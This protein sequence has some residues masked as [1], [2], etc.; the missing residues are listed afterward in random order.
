MCAT[1]TNF[2]PGREGERGAALVV[3]LLL[4]AFFAGVIADFVYNIRVNSYITANQVEQVRAKFVAEAGVNAARGI[5]LHST[6]FSQGGRSNFQNDYFNLFQCKCYTNS[7]LTGMTSSTE[8]NKQAQTKQLNLGDQVENKATDCGEWSLVIDYTMDED[9]LHL[10]IHDEQARI[11][12]NALVKKSLNPDEQGAALN[13]AFKPVVSELFKIRLSE[14]GMTVDDRELGAL[15]NL[16]VDW[17]DW[18]QVNGT[19]D[20]DLNETYQDG[21]IIY[22]NKNGPMDTVSELKMIPGITDEIYYA[23][24]DFLTV[25]PVNP[26]RGDYPMKVNADAAPLAGNFCNRA[27]LEFPSGQLH[28]QRSG[29]PAVCPTDCGKRDRGRRQDEAPRGASRIERQTQRGDFLAQRGSPQPRWYHLISTAVTPWGS[30]SRLTPW[31]WSFPAPSTCRSFTG[32]K[33]DRPSTPGTA[34][35]WARGRVQ[36]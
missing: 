21:D 31:S 25:Y 27:R 30:I 10:E 1:S 19:I 6:P 18:G 28:G 11:N 5:L 34:S 32:A 17:E 13:E 7:N 33:A 4:L 23:L 8:Q 2:K 16:V 12:L 24:K 20:S 36:P 14:L 29:R 15:I 26:D 9:L 35:G 3:V 22:S